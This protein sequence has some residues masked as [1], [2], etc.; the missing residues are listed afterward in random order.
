MNTAIFLGILRH[1]ITI[2]GGATLVSDSEL[3]TI[4]GALV[5]LAGV[6]WSIYEKRQKKDKK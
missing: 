3:Q 6:A 4:I 2:A 5:A 1:I